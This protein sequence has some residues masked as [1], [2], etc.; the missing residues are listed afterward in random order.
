M[1]SPIVRPDQLPP[2]N[3]PEQ[4][5][6]DFKAQVDPAN[7]A[8]LAKD[9]AALANATGGTLVV[10]AAE[11]RSQLSAYRPLPQQE[12]TTIARAYEEA[13]Q[14]L[15]RPLPIVNVAPI[16]K[17]GGYV[18]VVNVQP[19]PGQAVGVHIKQPETNRDNLYH[20][21]VRVGTQTAFITPEQIPM[22]TDAKIRRIAIVL[23]QAKGK[24]VDIQCRLSSDN[25]IQ[26]ANGTISAVD[27]STNTLEIGYVNQGPNVKVPLDVVEGVCEGFSGRWQLYLRGRFAGYGQGMRFM[28]S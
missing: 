20:Y 2:V 13:A 21:P 6:L 16:P 24:Q 19:F 25:R 10:G 26:D 14:R 1:W 17:D 3:T 9:V 8:E 18:V 23:E 11:T 15:V 4:T 22:Y 28:L 7:R 12:A 5:W 27:V